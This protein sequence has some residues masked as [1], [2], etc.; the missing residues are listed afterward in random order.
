MPAPG[1]SRW[2]WGSSW[3]G[4]A[5]PGSRSPGGGSPMSSEPVASLPVAAPPADAAVAIRVRDLSKR[6]QIYS[7]PRDRLKQSIY[8]RLQRLAGLAAKQ[9]HLDFWA[10][11]DVSFDVRR[12]E[13]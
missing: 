2:R 7:E 1:R 12:G 4:S 10:L 3:P 11:R 13:T 8:P 6:Y 5:S 9:Y